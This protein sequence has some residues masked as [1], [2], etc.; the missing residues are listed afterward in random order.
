M[1]NILP[2][3]V[4]YMTHSKNVNLTNT[5]MAC[6]FWKITEKNIPSE[7]LTQISNLNENRIIIN[8]W[9][10]FLQINAVQR[11]KAWSFIHESGW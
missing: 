2:G 4:V 6:F 9:L 8:F 5:S 3:R 10:N 1:Y 11:K 7:E